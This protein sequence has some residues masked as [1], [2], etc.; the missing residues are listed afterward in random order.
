MDGAHPGQPAIGTSPRIAIVGSGF[1]GLCMG[2]RLK[3]AGIDSFT[4]YEQADSIG[5]TWRDNHYP[6]AACDVQSHVYSFSFEKNPRWSRMFAEQTEIRDYLQHCADKYGLMRHMRFGSEVK[7]ARFDDSSGT[8]TLTL[9]SGEQVL[10]DVFV[11]AAGGLS[12]PA[13]PDIPGLPRFEGK[14]FHSARWDH[15]YDLQGKTVGVIGTGASAIQFVPQIVPK[16]AKLALF[17]RTPPFLLPK[18]DRAIGPVERKLYE[19]MP[20][21]QWLYRTALYLRMETRV[22]GFAGDP[23]LMAHPQRESLEYLERSVPDPK[24][25]AKLTPKYTFGCKRVL[26][27]NDYYPALTQPNVEVVDTGIREITATGVV[28]ADG[29]ERKLDALILGT[30]FITETVAPFPIAGKAG[31]DLDSHWKDGP[32]A[33]LGTTIAGYPN[34]F[35]VVGPN[36]GLGHSSMVLMIE[37]QVE[38]IMRA[39]GAL[40]ARAAQSI[41][42][43]EEVQARFN[44]GLQRRLAN[45]VWATGGCNSYYKNREGKIVALWPGFTFTFRKLTRRFDA[46]RFHFEPRKSETAPARIAPA[47]AQTNFG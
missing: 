33:Y 17:Q 25:R 20:G 16:V 12:R 15:S 27:S 46:A 45:T 29:Q 7:G 5:G 43:R 2:I 34:M 26:L 14:L 23:R 44:R 37:A 4:I 38:H 9:G 10:A 41:E 32:E 40:R 28:T 35:L 22:I 18:P 13:T 21:L 1:G 42:V 47:A 6:G 8:W 30:G 3:Q 36:T 24:L 31:V 19:F 11:S 39:L